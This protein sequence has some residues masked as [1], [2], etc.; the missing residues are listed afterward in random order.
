[1][2]YKTLKHLSTIRKIPDDLWDEIKLILPSERANNTI[3]RPVIPFRRK[4]VDGILYVLR[5]GCQWKMLPK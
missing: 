1:M 3:G 4:I 2:P 5:T